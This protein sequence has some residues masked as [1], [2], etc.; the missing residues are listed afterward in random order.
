M[1]NKTKVISYKRKGSKL[2]LFTPSFSLASLRS[3]GGSVRRVYASTRGSK[4]RK[5]D[6]CSTWNNLDNDWLDQHGI[7]QIDTRLIYC[8]DLRYLKKSDLFY[9]LTSALQMGG[10]K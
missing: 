2:T 5:S 3:K 1:A 10:A 8:E 6:M 4:F 9:N 7:R